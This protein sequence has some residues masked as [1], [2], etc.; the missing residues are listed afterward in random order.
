M[1]RMKKIAKFTL[2][3]VLCM[4]VL[5]LV[6]MHVGIA[7]AAEWP[8]FKEK[9]YLGVAIRSLSN[10]YHVA[11]KEGAEKL[12]EDLKANG[13]DVEV[14][15]L[16]CEGS[17]DRQ[18]SDIKALIARGG[19]NTVF[20]VDPNNAPNSAVIA[21]ICDDAGV[22]WASVWNLADDTYPMD[23]KYWVCHNSPDDVQAGYDIAVALFRSFKTPGKGKVLAVEGMMANTASQSRVAGLKKALAEYP[24]VELL[25][26]QPAEWDMKLALSTTET[27]LS[28]YS[29]I[30]GI[31]AADDTMALGVVTALQNA[32]KNGKIGVV[33]VAGTL[34]AV[35]AIKAGDMTATWDVNGRLQGYYDCAWPLAARLG[36]IDVAG[37]PVSDRMFLTAGSVV[38][39]SNVNSGGAAQKFD[40]RDL[41]SFNIKAMDNDWSK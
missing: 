39:A 2:A 6:G 26:Q 32:G 19:K 38:S 27:W 8:A 40:Y 5:M 7:S 10:P 36:V 20:Y 41:A 16:L 18:V 9:I 13:Y 17:D 22:Y 12:A 15:V 29:E 1:K 25:D 14:N 24:D 4:A 34:E 11:V 23:Y 37:L 28:K 33:G 31:W 30:D 21:D 35:N 3:L